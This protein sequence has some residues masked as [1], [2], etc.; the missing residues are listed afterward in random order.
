MTFKCRVDESAEIKYYMIL[1]RDLLIALGI[2]HKFSE[3]I[4][5][6]GGGPYG[7][8]SAPMADVNDYEFKYLTNKIIKWE[9][10]SMN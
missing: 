5:I 1:G 7:G 10:F 6:G 4:I 3:R 8:C 9:E 2:D